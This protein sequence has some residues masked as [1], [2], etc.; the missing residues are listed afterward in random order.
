MNKR[1]VIVAEHLKD[2]I[3]HVLEA[4]MPG[5]G[6]NFGADEPITLDVALRLIWAEVQ[7]VI[8][9]LDDDSKPATV[10]YFRVDAPDMKT[11]TEALEKPQGVIWGTARFRAARKEG[12]RAVVYLTTWMNLDPITVGKIAAQLQAAGCNVRDFS[13]GAYVR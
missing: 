13:A 8:M 9:Q 6:T 12:D 10:S 5:R 1:H 3:T 7:R 2:Y 4:F 11:L